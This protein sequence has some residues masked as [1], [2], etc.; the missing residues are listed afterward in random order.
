MSNRPK[1]PKGFG[2]FDALARR[3]VKVKPAEIP[4]PTPETLA[5]LASEISGPNWT[6]GW[7]QTLLIDCCV[8]KQENERSQNEPERYSCW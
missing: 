8:K 2:K 1:K 6:A 4:E 3:L 5:Q 7:G